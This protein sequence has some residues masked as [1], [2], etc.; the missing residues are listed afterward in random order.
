M[1]SG[2]LGVLLYKDT[3]HGRIIIT[4]SD[5]RRG[6][7]DGFDAEGYRRFLCFETELN[8]KLPHVFYPGG[9]YKESL[10]NPLP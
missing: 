9:S 2:S 1:T 7:A 4:E 8:K 3:T 10:N 6:V 5:N